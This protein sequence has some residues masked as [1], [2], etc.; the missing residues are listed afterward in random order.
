MVKRRK[1]TKTPVV[2]HNTD[3]EHIPNN[4]AFIGL[5]DTNL[6]EVGW[7]PSIEFV[8]SAKGYT[9]TGL[10]EWYTQLAGL[11]DVS[12]SRIES[13]IHTWM[14][15][16]AG[17]VTE[18]TDKV[19]VNWAKNYLKDNS[20]AS[21][22]DHGGRGE[23]LLPNELVRQLETLLQKKYNMYLGVLGGM[24]ALFDFQNQF[25]KYLTFD[26]VDEYIDTFNEIA[27][28]DEKNIYFGLA[29]ANLYK[30]LTGTCFKAIKQLP[31]DYLNK[32][33]LEVG[34]YA[35]SYSKDKK[36]NQEIASNILFAQDGTKLAH[37]DADAL[38]GIFGQASDMKK[39]AV[40]GNNKEVEVLSLR[41]AIF[42]LDVNFT[43]SITSKK[44]M[45][46][47]FLRTTGIDVSDPSVYHMDGF[48][49]TYEDTVQNF[50][51]SKDGYETILLD[52]TELSPKD[53]SWAGVYQL[54][55]KA[56]YGKF[57]EDESFFHSTVF[58]LFDVSKIRPYGSGSTSMYCD[59]YNQLIPGKPF[60]LFEF[61]GPA[62]NAEKEPV[63][64]QR[65]FQELISAQVDLFITL[66]MA[67]AEAT[68]YSSRPFI[69]DLISPI[70]SSVSPFYSYDY[71]SHNT[72]GSLDTFSEP[73]VYT[74]D[75]DVEVLVKEKDSSVPRTMDV[76][77]ELLARFPGYSSKQDLIID[78]N[79]F[80]VLTYYEKVDLV[81]AYDEF[82]NCEEHEVKDFLVSRG[83]DPDDFA[84]FVYVGDDQYVDFESSESVSPVTPPSL[85]S[86]GDA[87]VE[88]VTH[89]LSSES[90]SSFSE[91]IYQVE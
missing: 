25:V 40:I 56:C 38:R 35:T 39:M 9:T 73:I 74:E 26:M 7:N 4:E 61:N 65:W 28:V 57:E 5:G 27:Q 81:D 45:N 3:D 53:N 67:Y 8:L 10:N 20:L 1:R 44:M 76:S 62:N 36:H 51:R 12:R 14:K 60:Y 30:F 88:G 22:L 21:F 78:F 17:N 29:H 32:I 64:S 18:V 2:D 59:E 90:G 77:R 31:I 89:E 11:N 66:M 42:D 16:C 72:T 43:S 85:S 69:L 70:S 46:D 52:F 75:V 50:N 47:N 34:K 33:S 6:V 63:F 24:P 86:G 49:V 13:D 55:S 71:V 15:R 91:S 48:S 58:C 82:L 68:P 23:V 87:L 84:D 79:S 54:I 83:A 37:L 80:P 19:R 41:K